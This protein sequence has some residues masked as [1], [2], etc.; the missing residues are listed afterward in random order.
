MTKFYST[1]L[2]MLLLGT[3]AGVA[4]T[5][6]FTSNYPAA[7]QIIN[8]SDYSNLTIP[9]TGTLTVELGNDAAVNIQPNNGYQINSVSVNGSSVW[10]SGSWYLSSYDLIAGCT[11]AIDAS[12]KQPKTLTIVGDPAMVYVSF[13]YSTYG[14]DS[15]IDGQWN[16]TV[17]EDYGTTYIY[18][19]EDY[20]IRSVKDQYGNEKVFSPTQ[21][22]Y[23]YHGGLGQNTVLTVEAYNLAEARST[24]VSLEVVGDASAVKVTRNG[25]YNAIPMSDFG[26]IALNPDTELPLTIEHQIYSKSLYKLEVNGEEV[27][28]QGRSFRLTSL[29]DGDKLKVTTDFPEVR[30]PVN[31]TFVNEGTEDAVN[32]SVDNQNVLK[33]VWSAE[34]WGVMLGQNLGI[35]ANQA[36]YTIN[37]LSV[38]GQSVYSSWN[39]IIRGEDAVNVVVDATPMEPYHVTVYYSD[40]DAFAIYSDYY[41]TQPYELTGEDCTVLDV[42]RSSCTLYIQAS[43]GHMLDGV[44]DAND[45]SLGNSPY[46]SGDTEIFIYTSEF[47]RDRTLVFYIDENTS[48]T[49]AS[50]TLSNNNYD[51]RKEFN[52]YAS[53]P[54]NPIA[55]GYNFINF[56]EQDAPFGLGGYASSGYGSVKAYLNGTEIPNNYGFTMPSEVPDNS[57]LKLYGDTPAQYTVSYTIADDAPASVA[58]D[59][60]EEIE[61][62]AVHTV[63]AG[64]HCVI[65]V[66]A[67]SNSQ[68]DVKANGTAVEPDDL[69]RYIV[70]VNADTEIAVAKDSQTGVEGIEATAKT[71]SAVY[72]LQGI[73]VLDASEANR[74]NTLPAGIYIVGGKKVFTSK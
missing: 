5:V 32:V 66:K 52:Y 27:A 4:K 14:A 59:Y 13:Q 33:E 8:T 38:N 24:H 44:Y 62:P 54:D 10:G 11:V 22:C 70:P 2:L 3:V 46:I 56:A 69:G 21:S 9:E 49:Y 53:D 60:V 71:S 1:L 25:E 48:W 61:S 55:P 39:E 51:L 47:N 67:R 31:F 41:R 35:S 40:R 65:T 36:D 34:G 58:H 42:K 23:I 29:S 28:P 18:A 64:T 6:T 19:Y 15:N 45:N 68:L 16:F 26:D 63:Q 57:V 50:L 20:M 74:I 12:E 37:S 72:N 43:E 30:V 73:K 17:T 7:V